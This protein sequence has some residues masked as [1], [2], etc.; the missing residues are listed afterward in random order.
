[1]SDLF[2][3]NACDTGGKRTQTLTPKPRQAATTTRPPARRPKRWAAMTRRSGR[4]RK[5]TSAG[6][7]G[8]GFRVRGLGFRAKGL[9]FRVVWVRV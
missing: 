7:A 2:P 9:G 1:M 8:L 3:V 6:S 4:E 5:G